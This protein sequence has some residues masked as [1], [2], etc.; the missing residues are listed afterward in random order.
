M[1]RF[2]P[3]VVFHDWV[4]YKSRCHG[5]NEA[6]QI[7][8]CGT[9]AIPRVWFLWEWN[10]YVPLQGFCFLGGKKFQVPEGA[11]GGRGSEGTS[12][13]SSWGREHFAKCAHSH[14][15]H[16]ESNGSSTLSTESVSLFYLG[17]WL[18]VSFAEWQVDSSCHIY[19]LGLGSGLGDVAG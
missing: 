17:L 15:L 14:G 11:A 3:G 10:S 4:R 8:S 7:R 13:N 18:D 6:G 9:A 12:E 2:Q 19:T 16:R 1:P 5:W